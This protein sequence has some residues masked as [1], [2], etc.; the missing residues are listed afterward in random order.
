MNSII[1]VVECHIVSQLECV[2]NQKKKKVK[3]KWEITQNTSKHKKEI[4]ENL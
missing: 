2:N 4:K 1:I 3:L